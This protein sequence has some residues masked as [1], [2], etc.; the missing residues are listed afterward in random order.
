MPSAR[1]QF[2]PAPKDGGAGVGPP[3]SSCQRLKLAHSNSSRR[4]LQEVA[5]GERVRALLRVCVPALNAICSPRTRCAPRRHCHYP[6]QLPTAPQGRSGQTVALPAVLPPVAG[7]PKKP[8]EQQKKGK[9]E[10]KISP[11]GLIILFD[12][13]VF[14]IIGKHPLF[15]LFLAPF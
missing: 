13:R 9:K 12:R 1:G 2:G 6:H 14:L 4:C 3:V 10:R 5:A 8:L 7:A 15:F 11:N